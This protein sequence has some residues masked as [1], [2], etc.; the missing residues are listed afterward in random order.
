[1]KK[2]LGAKTIVYPTPVFIVGTYDKEERPDVMAAAWGGI[3]CSKPPCVSISLQKQ[4]YTLKNIIEREAFT[5]NIPSENYLE[6][7]DYFGI[8]SGRD[9]DKFS[10]TNLTPKKSEF[11]DAPF[12]KEFPLILECKLVHK[13]DLGMHIQ[14]TGEIID[15]KVDENV[16]DYNGI[17][18]ISKI[19]PIMY[20]P[21][22][23]AY[24]GVGKNL[25]KA[26]N[27]G[28]KIKKLE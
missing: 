8:V 15:V 14:I 27:L 23:V 9:H 16:I 6:E 21:A 28:K 12:I 5:I 4:R 11:V 17:P 1:M 18:D 26:F 7:A 2:S 20:D 3:S 24:Y 22:A 19:K 13:V 25:G 10:D